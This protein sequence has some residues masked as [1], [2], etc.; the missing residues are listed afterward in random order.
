MISIVNFTK[1]IVVLLELCCQLKSITR[2][3]ANCGSKFD[4]FFQLALGRLFSHLQ[5]I[6]SKHTKQRSLFWN[7]EQEVCQ[8]FR[9][10]KTCI[11][12]GFNIKEWKIPENFKGVLLVKSIEIDALT[13][14]FQT[15]CHHF[16]LYYIN[17]AYPLSLTRG[18]R[19]TREFFIR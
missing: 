7:S 15:V 17:A 8:N 1:I 14:E 11:S 6:A 3:L 4:L 18:S 9:N 19:R 13:F 16:R 5:H 2:G 12:R 10:K